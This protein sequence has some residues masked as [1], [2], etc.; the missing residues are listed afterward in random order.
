MWLKPGKMGANTRNKVRF[1]TRPWKRLASRRLALYLMMALTGGTVVAVAG[2]KEA[3]S[4][5]VF[6]LVLAVFFLNALACTTLQAQAAAR[7]ARRAREVS[8]VMAGASRSL[9]VGRGAP[10]D[11]WRRLESL[12]R[13]KGFTLLQR[14]GEDGEVVARGVRHSAGY[15][16]SAVF[17]GGLLLVILG[18]LVTVSTR[19]WGSFGVMEGDRFHDR[20]EDYVVYKRGP[21]VGE[22]HGQFEVYLEKV[23]L[24][25]NPENKLHDYGARVRVTG[26]GGESREAFI[27]GPNPLAFVGRIFYKQLFGYSPALILTFPEGQEISRFYVNI[28]TDLRSGDNIFYQGDFAIPRTPYQ[29]RAAFI[30]DLDAGSFPPRTRSDSPVNPALYLEVSREGEKVYRGVV[31]LGGSAEFDGVRLQFHHLK[32]WY[33]FSVVQDRGMAVVFTAFGVMVL[34]LF[35]TYLVVPREIT[36]RLLPAGDRTLVAVGG[37]S[38]KFAPLFARE[39][40]LLAREMERVLGNGGAAGAGVEAF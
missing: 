4:S 16:G 15:W 30:P 27:D 5:P 10:E 13:R 3:L 39:F 6:L 26:P 34:G 9:L 37:R 33:G 20:R 24:Q 36:V 22:K 29:A 14:Q 35:L 40:A 28:D 12:L 19:T 8:P 25:L 7:A 1:I 31:G 11:V 21:L 17:H 18:G 23:E 2:R 38:A 32:K